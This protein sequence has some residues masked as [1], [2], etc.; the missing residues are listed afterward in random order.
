MLAKQYQQMRQKGMSRKI[1]SATPRQLE[2]LIRLSEAFA[3]M[4]LSQL[5]E[6]LDVQAA[7]DLMEEA[8]LKT[9]TDPDTGIVNFDIITTGRSAAVKQ[10]ED[11]MANRV[12]AIIIA[13][14]TAFRKGTSIEKLEEHLRSVGKD[15]EPISRADLIGALRLLQAQ[16]LIV[17]FGG[18][19]Q[20]PQFKYHKDVDL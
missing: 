14:K 15:K 11:D 13:N 16:D 18:D 17:L 7:I 19:K 4:R 9:A 12:K 5:V 8:T 20:K 3:K 6:E 10:R 1:I 2:S